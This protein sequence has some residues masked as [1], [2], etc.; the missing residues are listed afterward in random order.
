[1]TQLYKLADDFARLADDD[2]PPEMIAD[3]LEG[4]QG[5]FEDK[6]EG[7]LQLIKNDQA[8]S[9][10]LREE[11]KRLAERRK[12]ADNR[13]DRLKEYIALC[14]E[15]GGLKKVRAG[16]QEVSTRKGVNSVVVSDAE[17][18]P[19]DLVDFKTET[20]PIKSEIKKRLDAG[21]EIKGAKLQMGKPSLII[22]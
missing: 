20:V 12:V 8:Y 2:L 15:K 4:M 13:V 11:E 5:V 1:M 22:K 10:A 21:E 7:M 6:L 14:M 9:A 18:L 16:L 19:D 17:L 3:T